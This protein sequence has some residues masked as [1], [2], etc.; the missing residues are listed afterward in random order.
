MRSQLWLYGVL[1]AMGFGWG[2]TIPMAK[3]AVST[4]YQPMGLIFWQLAVVVVLL[5]AVTLLRGRR[6]RLDR[7]Y[8]RLFVM[9]ALFGAVLPDIFY[10]LSAIYL[11]GGVMAITTSTVAMFSLP[12]AIALGNERFEARRL[13][14]VVFGMLG[15]FLLVGPKASLPEGTAIFV[16]L[17]LCAPALYA[18]EGNLVMKWGTQGLDP[19]QVIF[20]ASVVGLVISAPIAVVTGQWINP[21]KG[22]GPPEAALVAGA[23]LHALVYACYVWMVGR[24]GSVF[25]AQTSYIV[26]AFGVLSSMVILSE[27]YSIWVWLALA[28]MIM[29]MVL[30]QPRAARVLVP[31]RAFGDIEAG[32]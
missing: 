5:G 8:M 28:V 17:A 26:T 3:I 25:S 20:G 19:M 22:V 1:L 27:V 13:F 24:A 29:G 11:P 16:L 18:T 7:Q 15:V 14:G 4:G 6:L 30:V 12:I 21:L 23:A 32:Q 10:Y 2:L 31:G 9:V